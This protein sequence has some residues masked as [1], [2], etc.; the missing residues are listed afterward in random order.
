MRVR[1]SR[2]SK[3]GSKS[4]ALSLFTVFVAGCPVIPESSDPLPPETPPLDEPEAQA[5]FSE[6]VADYQRANADGTLDADECDRVA[7]GFEAVYEATH[8]EMV[9]AKFNV[10]AVREACGQVDKA[11]AVYAE[12]ADA[13]HHLALNNL[14][15]LAWEAGDVHGALALFDRSVKADPT[16]AYEARNN[17]AA[18]HRDR[19]AR[20][21]ELAEFEAAERQIH[22]VLA[23]DSSNKAA[24]ENLARLYYDRG[25]LEDPSFLVLANLVVTQALRVLEREGRSSA[26]I[27][28][29]QGL[30]LME[31]D[32]QV[33]A[34][35]AFK[36]AVEIEPSHPDANRN[37]G[38]IA[39]RFRDYASAE[40]AF[41]IALEDPLVARDIEVYIGMGVAKRGLRKFDEAEHWYREAMTVD[42]DDPRPWYNLGVLAQEHR[43]GGDDVD[44]DGIQAF[45]EAA[46]EHYEQ[47]IAL[48]GDDV[49]YADAV[50]DSRDRI[51]VIDDAI[52]TF[53]V[54]AGLADQVH[55]IEEARKAELRAMEEEARAK[56][57]AGENAQGA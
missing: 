8:R 12:L 28:N 30:L 2:W 53:E 42:D 9:T 38:F 55:A 15:V 25:R 11:K 50:A 27:R 40:R 17:L 13:G 44:T 7:N 46:R 47:F 52:Y 29:L 5:R 56:A 16:H 19:Y 3:S 49:G 39:I 57:A 43:I 32:N 6:V 41:A 54:M 35:R 20:S 26:D 51:A 31:D 37:I 23:V 1:K 22:R 33:V 36:K 4:L 18:A 45:Y 48:A 10:A 24:Y 34:L 14:G 21:V